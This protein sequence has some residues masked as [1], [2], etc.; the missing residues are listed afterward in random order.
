MPIEHSGLTYLPPPFTGHPFLDAVAKVATKYEWN[1]PELA[2]VIGMPRWSVWSYF[3]GRKRYSAEFIHGVI[4]ALE[5]DDAMEITT[6]LFKSIRAGY[7]TKAPQERSIKT[8][9]RQPKT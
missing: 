5:D 7:G 3:K 8:S 6:A 4:A 1:L 9:A 2:R